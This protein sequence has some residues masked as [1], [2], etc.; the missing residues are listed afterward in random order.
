VLSAVYDF[1]T[2]RVHL[3]F[4][5]PVRLSDWFRARLSEPGSI[6]LGF[7]LPAAAGTEWVTSTDLLIPTAN[8]DGNY[9]I[10]VDPG[11]A[12]DRAGLVSAGFLSDVFFILAG[13]ANHDRNIDVAD[14]K[15]MTANWM[16]SNRTF[17]QGDFNYDGKVDQTD[18][19]ILSAKWNTTLAPYVE[20]MPIKSPAPTPS[21]SSSRRTKSV[22][23][24]VLT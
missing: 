18:L 21:S 8:A 3:E 5:E 10:S 15:V 19:A 6:F 14:F 13:D 23:A 4:S 11:F 12:I 20:P 7:P 17:S 22:A 2:A 24:S 9:Q 16:Q 1:D